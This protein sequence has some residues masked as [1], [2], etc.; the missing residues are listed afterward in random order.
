MK[1]AKHT[2]NLCKGFGYHLKKYLKKKKRKKIITF[3]EG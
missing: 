3:E 2:I 1:R